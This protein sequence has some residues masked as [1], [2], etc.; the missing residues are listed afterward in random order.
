MAS[1]GLVNEVVRLKV[2]NA[3]K[4]DIERQLLQKCVDDNNRFVLDTIKPYKQ[5]DV[6]AYI[7]I[8]IVNSDF[9]KKMALLFTIDGFNNYSSETQ[10]C[11]EVS[12]M[13][14]EEK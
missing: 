5:Y 4:I 10:S 8:R 12:E 13:E 3:F 9:A 1:D 6:Q 7:A 14:H 11:N 2:I